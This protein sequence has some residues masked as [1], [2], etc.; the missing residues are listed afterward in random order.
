MQVSVRFKVSDRVGTGLLDEEWIELYARIPT[1]THRQLKQNTVIAKIEQYCRLHL[2]EN[3]YIKL[4]KKNASHFV[5][6][7]L[8]T[9]TH[10]NKTIK[11][12]F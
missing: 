7:V 8:T 12:C 3:G 5:L 11:T 10:E 9:Q 1:C 6:R 2:G 4:E